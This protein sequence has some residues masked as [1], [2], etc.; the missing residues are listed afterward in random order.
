MGPSPHPAL[1]ARD[2]GN[3]TSAPHHLCTL[4]EFTKPTSIQ[5][6]LPCHMPCINASISVKGSRPPALSTYFA[7][8]GCQK[9]STKCASEMR[10][11]KF[12]DKRVC[13]QCF[14]TKRHLFLRKRQL[15]LRK[16]LNLCL[17]KCFVPRILDARMPHF[18]TPW[19]SLT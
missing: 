4:A 17:A 7:Q 2:R 15:C 11:L 5:L 10:K 14:T 6:Y 8:A 19:Y 1:C 13:K 9:F 3:H 16:R 12:C 18:P